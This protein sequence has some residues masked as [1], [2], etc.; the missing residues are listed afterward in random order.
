MPTAGV[1][2]RL[3]QVG[4][5]GGPG[6]EEALGIFADLRATPD[7]GRT[8]DLLLAREGRDPLPEALLVAVASAL[9]DRGQPATA[10]RVLSR[11][12]SCAALVV[13]A[14]ILAAGGDVAAALDEVQRVLLHDI[15]WPGARERH[16]RWR[17][18]LGQVPPRRVDASTTLVTSRPDAPFH[19]L[20]EIARGGAGAVYEAE[21]RDLGRRVALKVYHRI[22]RDRAQLLHEARVAAALAGRG[23]VRVFDVDPEHGWLAMEWARL[24]ALHALLRSEGER[25]LSELEGWAVPL[26]DALARVHAAGWV[27]NDIKPANVLLRGPREPLLTDFGVAR[28]AGEPSPPGSLGYVSPERLEGRA[29]D[30]RDDVFAFGRVLECALDALGRKGNARAWRELAATCTGPD[31]ARPPHAGPLASRVREAST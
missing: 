23:V 19:L 21:D 1:L 17:A 6:V 9:V 11:A 22:D 16:E 8:V 26:A 12:D 29:S 7:E 10:A 4:V 31:R 13:R 24:G 2:E 27:H 20:R 25:T 18:A 28:R 5:P 3:L 30:P 14:D 15:D